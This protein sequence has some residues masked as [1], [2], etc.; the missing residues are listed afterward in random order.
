MDNYLS[1]NTFQSLVVVGLPETKVVPGTYILMLGFIIVDNERNQR[2]EREPLEREIDNLLKF[3]DPSRNFGEIV[4]KTEVRVVSRNL[5]LYFSQNGSQF[6]THVRTS[7]KG[8]NST[9]QGK[10]L[11]VLL[12]VVIVRKCCKRRVDLVTLRRKI[13]SIVSHRSYVCK[14]TVGPSIVLVSCRV[15]GRTSEHY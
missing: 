12:T 4:V 3:L 14:S 7:E 11:W 8:K 13:V 9:V 15:Q 1:R 5:L 6:T 2:V 10:N